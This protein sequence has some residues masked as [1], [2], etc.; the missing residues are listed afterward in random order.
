MNISLHTFFYGNNY[1]ALLQSLFLKTYLKNQFD[2]NVYFDRYQPSQFLY[3]EEIKPIIKKNIFHSYQGIKKFF[4]LRKWKKKYIQCLPSKKFIPSNYD[5]N[6]L[7]IYGSDEVWNFSNPFFGFDPFFFGK[8]NKNAKFSYAASFGN[9]LLTNKNNNLLNEIESLLRR[10][11][12]ISVRDQNSQNF[13][14]DKFNISSEIVLDPIFLIDNEFKI[15]NDIEKET[16]EKRYCLIY[17]KYFSDNEIKKIVQLSK[18]QNLFILSVGYHNKWADLN[19]TNADPFEFLKLLKMSDVIFTSM[20]HGVQFSVKYN[21]KF[22]YTIDP[23][24]KNK[25]DFFLKTLKLENRLIGSNLNYEDEIDYLF[26]NKEIKK[27]KIQSQK[28][29]IDIMRNFNSL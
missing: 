9:V 1:G 18:N 22:W 6:S 27:K 24:R 4:K 21:K 29:I 7:S 19:I 25:L 3:R 26:I 5:E 14:K 16:P 12:N 23:Y 13:L 17:G 15:F 20:F 10:F 8:S 28:F 2:A 11:K